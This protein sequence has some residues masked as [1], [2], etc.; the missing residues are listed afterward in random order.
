MRPDRGLNLADWPLIAAFAGGRRQGRRQSKPQMRVEKLT[1]A[2]P[3]AGS[4]RPV[5]DLLSILF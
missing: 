1:I 2:F 5:Y 3:Q 4:H